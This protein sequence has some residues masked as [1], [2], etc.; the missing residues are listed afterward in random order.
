M[1]D[2][3]WASS[4]RPGT[5]AMS[6]EADNPRILHQGPLSFVSDWKRTVR[7]PPLTSHS[8]VLIDFPKAALREACSPIPPA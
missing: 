6:R 5:T 4:D 8:A 7:K 1:N 3:L 2:R